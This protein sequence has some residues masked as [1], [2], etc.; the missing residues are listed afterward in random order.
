MARTMMQLVRGRRK[1]KK[2]RTGTRF[3]RTPG[4]WTLRPF[5]NTVLKGRRF[6][7]GMCSRVHTVTPKKPNSALRKVARIQLSDGTRVIARIP[8][9]G[10]HQLA[11]YSLVLIRGGRVKD[12]PGIKYKVVRGVYDCVPV[13]GRVL[14]RSKY[15]RKRR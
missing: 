2:K 3:Y 4:G 15:G 12:L 6:R 10:I 9:E 7:K 14:R 11:K 13:A 5:K 1:T 8:G